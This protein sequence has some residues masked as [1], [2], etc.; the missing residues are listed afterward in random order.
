M[1]YTTDDNGNKSSLRAILIVLF[2]LLA[3]L[4]LTWNLIFLMEATTKDNP[5]YTGLSLIISAILGGGLFGLAAKVIQK[6]YESKSKE[7]ENDSD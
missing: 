5:D 7:N 2:G 6:K 3:I 1:S 4:L